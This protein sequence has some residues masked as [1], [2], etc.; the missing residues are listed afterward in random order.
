MAGQ[1]MN[2]IQKIF[3]NPA[4]ESQSTQQTISNN[5]AQNSPPQSTEV[6]PKTAGNGTVPEG[7]NKES[8]EDKFSKLWEPNTT[9]SKGDTQDSDGITPQQ[10][11]EAASKV[12]F[13][14]HVTPEDMQ[15]IAAGG[16]DAVKTLMLVM[17][18]ANQGTYAQSMLVTNK[19]I[20]KYFEKAKADFAS[21]VPGLVKRQSVNE[22][23]L[24]DNPGFNDPAV[25]PVVRM[26]QSQLADKYPN[27][28]A[29]ELQQ[30][31]KEYFTGAA[32]KL[33]PPKKSKTTES[34]TQTDDWDDWVQT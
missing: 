32:S 27:A 23:L 10:M 13:T 17:N 3:G 20:E 14:K 28:S 25:A 19:M 12:D 21:Q 2:A 24:K 8:P 7:S 30:M 1:V 22:T 6:S 18:K 4:Q 31:A 33:S 26:I 29:D 15:K 9:E 5:P 16:E 34:D 11:M